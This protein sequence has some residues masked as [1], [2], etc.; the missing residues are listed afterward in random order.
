[1][2][3]WTPAE[4]MDSCFTCSVDL[5]FL[6]LGFFHFCA[7]SAREPQRVRGELVRARYVIWHPDTVHSAKVRASH[8]CT[9]GV[10]FDVA[11]EIH[12][13][14][15]GVLNLQLFLSLQCFFKLTISS[16]LYL[17]LSI[18]R[19]GNL[20]ASVR[21]VSICGRLLLQLDHRFRCMMF[22]DL[23]Y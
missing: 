2:C 11:I 12:T 19:L 8:S 4:W 14:T 13:D 7:C 16:V 17:C 5:D 1:M 3:N 20:V 6:M 21:C 23:V 15:C 18:A 22:V 9:D 10:Q